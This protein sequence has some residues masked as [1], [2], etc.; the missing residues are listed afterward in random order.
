[1][2]D[3]NSFK[4]IKLYII[5]IFIIFG[6]AIMLQ[7][8]VFSRATVTG[9]SMQPT[10]SN[11]DVIFVEKVSTEIGHISRGEIVIFNS[12]DENNDTY[13]K[14]VIGI[15]GDRID[16]KDSQVYLNGKLLSEKY[17]PAG[18]RTEPN[19]INTKY[20]IPK[21]HIFVLGDNRSNSTDSR[22]LG[23]ISLKNIKG[24]VVLRVY[25]FNKI[26]IF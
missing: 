5:Y 21:G 6:I 19:S 12:K 14:R 4:N 11:K 7:R 16:I 13:I 24:H 26:N 3:K 18:V 23:P 22:I 15:A 1:M 20:T 10:F 2:K 25:P 17:L 8:Y 9:P